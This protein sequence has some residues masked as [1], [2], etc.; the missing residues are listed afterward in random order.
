MD[1]CFPELFFLG[2]FVDALLIPTGLP[3]T[4]RA[5]RADLRGIGSGRISWGGRPVG[6]PGSQ[7]VNGPKG[8]N[9]IGPEGPV[10]HKIVETPTKRG[11]HRF[12][13][14]VDNPGMKDV[15]ESRGE[16]S[17]QNSFRLS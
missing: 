8:R 4:G 10:K 2:C 5:H 9:Q 12:K 14:P 7:R 17:T 15:Q 1:L 16:Q 6:A 13:N 3:R 11:G